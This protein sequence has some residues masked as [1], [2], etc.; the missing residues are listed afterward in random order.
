MFAICWRI[1][2]RTSSLPCG[3]AKPARI[4]ADSTNWGDQRCAGSSPKLQ[5]LL[6]DA[7]AA[8]SQ[9]FGRREVGRDDLVFAVTQLFTWLDHPI[10]L[11][12]LV[13]VLVEAMGLRRSCV[14]EESAEEVSSYGS[15]REET[16]WKEYLLWLWLQMEKLSPRQSV[17]FLLNSNVIRDFELFW[18]GV[19]PHAGAQVGDDAGA[20][21]STWQRL[22]LDDL[23][24]AADVDT[25]QQVINLRRVARDSLGKAWSDYAAETSGIGNTSLRFTSSSK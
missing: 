18:H 2:L 23:A 6:V 17:S 24:L 7:A 21:R 3:L 19:D 11:R 14:G 16:I 13:S 1:A 22:P 9:A 10:E 15:P 12:D 25:R 20:P 4:Y 8:A 5:W